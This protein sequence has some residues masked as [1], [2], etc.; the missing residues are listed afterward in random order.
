MAAGAQQLI[1]EVDGQTLKLT[2]LGKVLYPTTGFTKAEVI[3]YYLQ[4]APLLLPHLSDR[5]LTRKRWPDGTGAA[6]FFEK[7][8]PRGTPDW[9][10]TVTLPTPG[11]STGRDEADFVVADNIPTIVWLAN[12][13]ALELHVPQWRIGLSDNGKNPHADLVVFDLDP[14]PPATVVDCCDVALALRELLGHHGLECW[15]KT[16]GNKGLHLYA[17]IEPARSRASSAFAKKIAEQLAEALPEN[18]TAT[19]TKALR[20]GKVFIDW[21]QNA[22]AKTTLAPYSL[23]GADEPRVSTPIDWDEVAAA[24]DPAELV[25]LPGDVLARIDEYGDMLQG[26]YDAPKPLPS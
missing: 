25:F 4:V 26:L 2:N 24:T 3:D 13:A 21:S 23:R 6:Y 20:P 22:S 19:M 15:A 11:S 10:R 14:G 5:P 9:V 12:L 17:P 8:A 18:V 7:N 1:T 16:S